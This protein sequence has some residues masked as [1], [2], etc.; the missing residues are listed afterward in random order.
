[1]ILALPL[2][3]DLITRAL[4]GESVRVETS[5]TADAPLSDPLVMVQASAPVPVANG[6]TLESARF[7]IQVSVHSRNRSEAQ[8]LAAVAWI[9]AQRLNRAGFRSDGNGALTRVS[10]SS[11]GPHSV[12]SALEVDDLYRFDV[13]LDVI[14]RA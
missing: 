8:R 5:L 14:A 4:S 12:P 10:N 1:M 9:G 3:Y 11:A 13:S 7:T 6:P 2:A